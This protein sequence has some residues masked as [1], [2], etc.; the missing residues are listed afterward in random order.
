MEHD[1]GGGGV[2]PGAQPSVSQDEVAGHFLFAVR[3]R[4]AL[5]SGPSWLDRGA[6]AAAAAPLPPILH[7]GDLTSLP[8]RTCERLVDL[9]VRAY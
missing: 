2:G 7:P 1:P 8:L 9:H 4:R 3:N 6:A 5:G